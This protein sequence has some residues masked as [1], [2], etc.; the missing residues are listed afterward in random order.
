VSQFLRHSFRQLSFWFIGH[1]LSRLLRCLPVHQTVAPHGNERLVEFIDKRHP[2]GNITRL[3][4]SSPA[5]VSRY[6]TSGCRLFPWAAMITLF[7]SR[8]VGAT[9]SCQYGKKRVI[10]SLSASVRG[11]YF[12]L[13][14][15]VVPLIEPP[16][17]MDRYPH[18]VHLFK[19]KLESLD[20]PCEH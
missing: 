8:S 18:E 7:P 4:I 1:S 10:V 2:C 5:M 9:V 15:P 20:G 12:C 17:V 19:D 14:G 11:T 13:E 6:L 16:A 3:T